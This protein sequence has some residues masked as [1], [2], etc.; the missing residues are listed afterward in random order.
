M[1]GA[2]LTNRQGLRVRLL[3]ALIA[4]MYPG[5]GVS[6]KW[7]VTIAE[8]QS[9]WVARLGGAIQVDTVPPFSA[10][11]RDRTTARLQSEWRPAPPVTL[12]L[13]MEWIRDRLPVGTV[14]SGP[15]DLRLGAHAVAW[16]GPVDLGLGWQVKLPNARDDVSLGTDETDGIVVGTVATTTGVVRLDAYGGVA[17]LGDPIRFAAQDDVPVLGMGASTTW[18]EVQWATRVEGELATA[19]N[20]ARFSGLFGLEGGCRWRY[21]TE[22][23]FG[24]SQAAPSWGIGAWLGVAAG[25]SHLRGD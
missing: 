21:G 1:R 5:V 15:G 24:L 19:R 13:R 25:C 4:A 9:A 8:D 17:T 22:G 12:D 10:T 23:Q 18:V 6:A 14:V 3:F 7:P 20:P 11:P 16:S 2:K